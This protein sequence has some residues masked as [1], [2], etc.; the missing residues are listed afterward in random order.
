MCTFRGTFAFNDLSPV[1]LCGQPTTINVYSSTFTV[2]SL[3][4]SDAG[5]SVT[6]AGGYYCNSQYYF[7]FDPD[8]GITILTTNC[9]SAYCVF[10]T[11][12]DNDTFYSAG[13]YQGN[14][15]YTGATSGDY[16]Y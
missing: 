5:C 15:Y 10:D 14:Y 7:F 2:G 8:L 3:L 6:L 11:V 1:G 4:Y 9:S 13:T 12:G 16:I